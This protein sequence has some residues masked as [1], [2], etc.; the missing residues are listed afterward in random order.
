MQRNFDADHRRERGPGG[1]VIG[2]VLVR[3][4]VIGHIS[5]PVSESTHGP[6]HQTFLAFWV[7]FGYRASDI[8][9]L[10]VRYGDLASKLG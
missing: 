3:D 4:F 2:C 9:V 5:T 10:R 6:G 7:Q 1:F 8:V